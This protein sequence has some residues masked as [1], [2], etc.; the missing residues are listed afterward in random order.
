MTALSL[1]WK[2]TYQENRRYNPRTLSRNAYCHMISDLTCGSMTRLRWLE[3]SQPSSS[4]FR[5]SRKFAITGT[6]DQ[7]A[8]AQGMGYEIIGNIICYTGIIL[9]RSPANERKRCIVKPSLIDCAHTQNDSCYISWKREEEN[10]E[11]H[12]LLITYHSIWIYITE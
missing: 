3:N 10:V 9:C 1:K 2:T 4:N 8:E 5:D 12:I 11:Y 7:I 6:M